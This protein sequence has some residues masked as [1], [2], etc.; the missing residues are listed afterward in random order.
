MVPWEGG[1][2]LVASDDPHAIRIEGRILDGAG[3][4]V[5]D[6]VIE[7]WQA[8]VHGR[9]AHVEDTREV[10]LVEGFEGFGRAIA[11]GEGRFTLVTVKPG[12]V[13]GAGESP[14]APHICLSVF[15]RGLLKHLVTRIY[16]SDEKTA[17]DKDPVLQSIDDTGRRQTLL[18]VKQESDGT[19]PVYEFEIHLQG[20]RETVFFDV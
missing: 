9:Y 18:A 7:V 8:N 16:F 2:E 4:P 3:Q 14:Q 6:S 12:C 20:P 17:N 5:D 1:A 10:P 15:A 13:P 19:P 11:D